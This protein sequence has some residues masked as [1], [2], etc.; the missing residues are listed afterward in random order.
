MNGSR[1][2]FLTNTGFAEYQY[3]GRGICHCRYFLQGSLQ[4]HAAT[5]DLAEID[6]HIDFVA[7][8]ITVKR[9]VLTRSE[10]KA[11]SGIAFRERLRIEVEHDR[12]RRRM[13]RRE[14]DIARGTRRR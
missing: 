6:C 3:V 8:V 10:L 13:A 11:L 1:N 12:H 14:A 4:R 5:D 2:H 9:A 7:E